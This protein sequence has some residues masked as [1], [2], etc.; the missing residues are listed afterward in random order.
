MKDYVKNYSINNKR[1]PQIY[2]LIKKGYSYKEILKELNLKKDKLSSNIAVLIN[3]KLISK[4]KNGRS[5]NLITIKDFECPCCGR[6][7]K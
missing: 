5:V 7:I 2:L 4:K 1:L 6:V 3:H